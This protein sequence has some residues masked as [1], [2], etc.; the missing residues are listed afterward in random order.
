MLVKM[1][2]KHPCPG[3]YVHQEVWLL[4]GVIPL[5]VQDIDVRPLVLR[6]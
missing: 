3:G 5:Y 2:R 4:F 6:R 1:R